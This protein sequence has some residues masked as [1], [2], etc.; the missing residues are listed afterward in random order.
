MSSLKSSKWEA[1]EGE[2]LV[3]TDALFL[4]PG[5]TDIRKD[6]AAGME[7][8]DR[9]EDVPAATAQYGIHDVS[10]TGYEAEASGARA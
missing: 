2:D 9:V 10:G 1:P 4:S 8:E 3:T 6:E 7:G 5:A